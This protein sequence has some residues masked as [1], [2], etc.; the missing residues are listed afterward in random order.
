M[1]R[2]RQMAVQIQSKYVDYR[3]CGYYVAGTRI[4]LDVIVYEF[5]NGQ[6]PED[7][8]RSYPSLG[9]LAKVYGVITFIL[10]HP[11]E[12]EQYLQEQQRLWQELRDNYPIPPEMTERIRKAKEELS[13]KSA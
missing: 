2:D 12:V 7:I 5:R 3:E 9:S 10:E 1:C 13:K 6:L 11:E 4:G 8:L